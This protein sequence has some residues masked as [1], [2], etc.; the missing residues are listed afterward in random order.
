MTL[1]VEDETRHVAVDALR[2]E[3]LA[4]EVEQHLGESGAR[5]YGMRLLDFDL[6]WRV[7]GDSAVVVGL[8]GT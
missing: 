1:H 2:H 7:E 8:D 3:G 6:R 4:P 5:V